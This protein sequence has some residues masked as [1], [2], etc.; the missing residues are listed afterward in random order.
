MIH[1]YKHTLGKMLAAAVLFLTTVSCTESPKETVLEDSATSRVLATVNG[2]AITESMVEQMI[3]RTLSNVSAISR[4]DQ[5][6]LNKKVLESLISSRAMMQI[7]KKELATEELNDIKNMA[8]AYEEEL[9]V[10]AYLQQY[11]DPEPVSSTMV[12]EYYEQHPEEFGGATRRSFELLV[13]PTNLDVETQDALVANLAQIRSEKNWAENKV[14]WFEKYKLQLQVGTSHPGLLDSALVSALS[15]LE[16]NETS[17]TVYLDGQL[18]II[19][20]TGVQTTPAKNL[21]EVSA[22]IRKKLSPLVVR[23]AVKAASE[24]ARAQAEIVIEQN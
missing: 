13:A 10:K 21:F 8:R 7:M 20:L 2:E 4:A 3:T 17:N 14:V 11:A 9:Y 22:N 19:R 18:H 5:E 12:R 6:Q 1:P 24:T 23:K 16:E 15:K